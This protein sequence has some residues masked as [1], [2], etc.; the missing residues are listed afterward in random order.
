MCPLNMISFN[1]TL[2]LS[3]LWQTG[4]HEMEDMTQIGK[5]EMSSVTAITGSKYAHSK[6]K[7]FQ[8]RV[9]TLQKNVVHMSHDIH[10]V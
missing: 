1:F 3:V 7:V 4:V 9:Y 10:Y 2:I 5:G 8:S 6:A